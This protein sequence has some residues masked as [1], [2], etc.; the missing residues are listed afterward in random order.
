MREGNFLWRN[1][2][3]GK[4]GVPAFT[5]V[6]RETGT[7]DTGWG[8]AGKFFDPDNDGRLDL[9]V[10]NG[11]VSA[12]P[13]SYVP[14]IFAMIVRGGIDL[15][16][17]RNWPPMRDKS[18]SGYQRNRFFRNGGAVFREEAARHG[19]DSTRDGRGIAVADFDRDGRQ[20]LFVANADALPALYHNRVP[21]A[22]EWVAF[23]LEGRRSNRDGIGARLWLTIGGRRLL[24]FVDGG[25]GFAGQSSRRVHFGLGAA[26][27]V[28]RLEVA[29]PSGARQSFSGFAAGRA[30]RIVEGEPELQPLSKE[31]DQV[32]RKGGVK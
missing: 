26:S 24:R 17:A 19:L 4:D 22:G 30:Y 15:S 7:H 6:A 14:D 16:D 20:D 3:P 1:G 18:L 13:E 11:W 25:N 2:G 9:Y 31:R 10:V 21:S 27:T 23:Q 5:D 8:W 28:E 12:G 32:G 29:W